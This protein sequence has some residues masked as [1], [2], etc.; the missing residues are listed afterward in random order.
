MKVL[1]TTED[2]EKAIEGFTELETEELTHD[3]RMFCCPIVQALKREGFTDVEVAYTHISYR[4]GRHLTYTQN[5]S[6]QA[7]NFALEFDDWFDNTRI[8]GSLGAFAG[9]TLTLWDEETAAK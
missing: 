5:I 3:N 8:P 6:S 1:I 7:K 4:V 9:R 2:V